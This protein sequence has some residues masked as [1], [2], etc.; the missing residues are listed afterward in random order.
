MSFY[1]THDGM[2]HFCYTQYFNTDTIPLI[3]NV[4]SLTW[5]KQD[6]PQPITKS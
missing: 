2:S 4:L 1:T 5:A 3:L 6:M